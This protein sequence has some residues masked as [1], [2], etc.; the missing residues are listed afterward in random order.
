MVKKILSLT[1]IVCFF[2]TSLTPLPQAH[3]D[4]VLGLPAPGT[5]VRITSQFQPAIIKGIKVDPDNPLLFNFLIDPGQ[6]VLNQD[7]QKSEYRKL[8]KYFLAALTTPEHDMWVNLSPYEHHR[9]TSN[10]LGQTEM[11]RDMLAQ[12]YILKQLTA[13]LIYPEE[14]LGKKFWNEIYERVR[15]ETGSAINIP[16]NTFNKVWIIPESAT[17][18][19]K[20]NVA[21]VV[22]SHMKVLL[23]QDYLSLD[24]H[25]NSDKNISRTSSDVV[26]QIILP[27]IEK[28][29][30]EGKNFAN[31]RQIYNSMILAS[32]FKQRLKIHL[33]S[34]VY[35]NKNENAGVELQ[36]P[37]DNERIY[38]D[39][40]KAFKKGV[41]NYIKEDKD[42]ASGQTV[43]RKYFSGGE[44]YAQLAK[45]I[46]SD[47]AVIAVTSDP[48][49]VV[50]VANS[51]LQLVPVLLS[52]AQAHTIA[53][54]NPQDAFDALVF[55]ASA[56]ENSGQEILSAAD[57]KRM[58]KN[59]LASWGG[60]PQQIVQVIKFLVNIYNKEPK[61]LAKKN[62]A[63]SISTNVWFDLHFRSLLSG[64]SDSQSQA[65]A[66]ALRTELEN[67]NVGQPAGSILYK[68]YQQLGARVKN[69]QVRY[70]KS[71]KNPTVAQWWVENK[72]AIQI[73]PAQVNEDALVAA[74]TTNL[75][76]EQ[77][78]SAP[79][80]RLEAKEASEILQL[81]VEF[82]QHVSITRED[83]ARMYGTGNEGKVKELLKKYDGFE[84][85]PLNLQIEILLNE[86]MPL[87]L[88]PTDIIKLG[89]DPKMVFGIA[90][91]QGYTLESLQTAV[92]TNLQGEVQNTARE[93]LEN[94]SAIQSASRAVE[95]EKVV[96]NND[97][98]PSSEISFGRVF[99]GSGFLRFLLPKLAT[100][101]LLLVS[102]VIIFAANNG[103]NLS[104]SDQIANINHQLSLKVN[105]ANIKEMEK[106]RIKLARLEATEAVKKTVTPPPVAPAKTVTAPAVA[107]HLAKKPAPLGINDFTPK[108][109][110]YLNEIEA[111]GLHPKAAPGDDKAKSVRVFNGSRELKVGQPFAVAG[112]GIADNQVNTN[113]VVNPDGI[114]DTVIGS[115]EVL[116]IFPRGIDGRIITNMPPIVISSPHQITYITPPSGVSNP[117]VTGALSPEVPKHSN[118][119]YIG[120]PSAQAR[121]NTLL[122]A[123]AHAPLP[124]TG[125]ARPT[126]LPN[127]DLTLGDN[128]Y[129]EG[130]MVYLSNALIGLSTFNG[131][132]KISGFAN[133]IQGTNRIVEIMV[134][135]G[136]GTIKTVEIS[137]ADQIRPVPPSPTLKEK[138]KA[139]IVNPKVIRVEKV[140]VPLSAIVGAFVLL[141]KKDK[142]SGRIRLSTPPIMYPPDAESLVL[143]H[144]TGIKDE[145]MTNVGGIDFDSKYL[146]MNMQGDGVNIPI[147]KGF[148]WLL[149]TP[150]SGFTPQILDI[151]SGIGIELSFFKGLLTPQEERTARANFPKSIAVDYKFAMKE[152][153]TEEIQ[154]A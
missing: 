112:F 68:V 106:L 95:V 74:Y 141:R 90:L 60:N 102:A 3:A 56:N 153:V 57:I 22:K 134:K 82:L 18:F 125:P 32:W 128:V 79:E 89:Y 31:I 130:D 65:F 132:G 19:E 139:L 1:V 84:T 72:R 137:S 143:N 13:S 24:K 115:Y 54:N 151:R 101:S 5:M 10:N 110:I 146:Q 93:F 109:K 91:N 118:L 126:V 107:I 145:A 8:I 138:A 88:Y 78:L 131:E 116:D 28:E 11:G 69:T 25:V 16:V 23:D 111:G 33:L 7:E 73:L 123:P 12:D 98:I 61:V 59:G 87:G 96:E 92:E 140:G 77:G 15:M 120:S 14:S 149:K 62:V 124:K 40:L 41:F 51:K 135:V 114:S 34:K 81:D 80:A 26:R 53:T 4:S 21:I 47:K 2:L 55:L 119:M 63:F 142:P 43:T 121:T 133:T 154:V 38:Q 152:W 42:S 64:L 83:L 127:G 148:N 99:E 17:V 36:T 103:V 48:D 122:L 117:T 37:Q 35:V 97:D 147:P 150:I 29:V 85:K 39:Y 52:P 108:L 58:T 6:I 129:R 50:G 75:E 100:T 76:Q 86:V 67:A 94:I 46:G 9:M 144:G 136:D 30:N 105:T 70:E 20:G 27:A 66:S 113:I 44:K 45:L 49:S 104:I 71:L